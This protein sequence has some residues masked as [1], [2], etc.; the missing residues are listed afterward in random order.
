MPTIVN[1]LQICELFFE[2]HYVFLLLM[3]LDLHKVSLEVLREGIIL[4]IFQIR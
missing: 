3:L 1:F 4:T 2:E